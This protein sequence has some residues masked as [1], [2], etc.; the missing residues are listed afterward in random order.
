MYPL[1]QPVQALLEHV[2]QF[3]QTLLQ[4]LQVPLLR[5]VLFVQAVQTPVVELQ[6]EQLAEQFV[7]APLP[8]SA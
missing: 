1:L 2:E 6:L 7:Q 4:A 8:A 3:D 5:A